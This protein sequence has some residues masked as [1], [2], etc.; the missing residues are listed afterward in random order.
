LAL[1][2]LRSRVGGQRA[3]WRSR[4]RP[5]CAGQLASCGHVFFAGPCHALRVRAPQSHGLPDIGLELSREADVELRGWQAKTDAPA[6]TCKEI[7][8]KRDHVVYTCRPIMNKPKPKPPAKEPAAAPAA[9]AGEP[10][11]LVSLN[12]KP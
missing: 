6:C 8:S 10:C 2:G 3:V 5:R 12:P 7:Y 4:A 9:D 11:L 1:G